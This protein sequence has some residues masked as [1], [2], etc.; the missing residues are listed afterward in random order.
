M[1]DWGE[2]L[3]DNDAAADLAIDWDDYVV[4]GRE[5][6]PEFWTPERIW[7]FFDRSH[8]RSAEG[9]QWDGTDT[10]PI[11]LALGALFLRDGIP[12]PDRLRELVELAA[13]AE[14][15]PKTLRDWASP[16]KRKKVLDG[17]LAQIGGTVRT[18]ETPV[19]SAA[20]ESAA[21][22][23]FAKQWPRWMKVLKGRQG[24]SFLG[25]GSEP[26]MERLWPPYLERLKDALGAGARHPDEKVMARTMRH[27]LMAWAFLTGWV[28]DLPEEE[29]MALIG[30]AKATTGGEHPARFLALAHDGGR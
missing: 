29:W 7:R 23:E 19:P 22:A 16:R 27:R 17:F 28:L 1:G 6:D 25:S 8:V 20:A 24:S 30:R 26:E 15:R 12:M 18:V 3:L 11:L 13:S 14:I 2:G 21:I 4:R 9:V 10:G 5:R